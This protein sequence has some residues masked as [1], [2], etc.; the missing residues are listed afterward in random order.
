LADIVISS[1]QLDAVVAHGRSCLPDEACGL[2]FGRDGRVS[3]VRPVSNSEPSPVSYI[4]DPRDQMTAMKEMEAEGLELVGIYHTHP[5]SPAMP[6]LTDI[7]RAFF[8]GTKEPNFPDAV[9]LIVGLS[10]DVPEANAFRILED[11]VQKVEVRVE[12]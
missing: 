11:G 8:P 6:S 3:R 1:E 12:R 2:L 4:L 9:Y 7:R 5:E 10:G